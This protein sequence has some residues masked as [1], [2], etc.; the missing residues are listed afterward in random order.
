[1]INELWSY[2]PCLANGP[3]DVNGICES[4]CM[5]PAR[6]DGPHEYTPHDQIEIRVPEIAIRLPE[7]RNPTAPE[8]PA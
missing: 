4:Q 2:V 3:V 6:H 1:M 8:T 5:L 7:V